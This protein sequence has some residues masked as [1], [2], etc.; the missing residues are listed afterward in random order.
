MSIC[1]GISVTNHICLERLIWKIP[2]LLCDAPQCISSYKLIIIVFIKV[3][4]AG[5]LLGFPLSL[6]FF[7]DQNI[8]ESMV[9]SPDN[10][11]LKGIQTQTQALKLLADWQKTRTIN[12]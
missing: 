4:V 3:I 5:M 12:L 11:L 10:K 2:V 9:N 8:S 6:L 1:I 7:I